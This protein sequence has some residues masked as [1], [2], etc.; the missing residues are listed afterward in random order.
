MDQNGPEPENKPQ[1]DQLVKPRKTTLGRFLAMLRITIFLAVIITAVISILPAESLPTFN[2]NLIFH[3]FSIVIA[4]IV[5]LTLGVIFYL[6]FAPAFH[7]EAAYLR[8]SFDFESM[9]GIVLGSL[10]LVFAGIITLFTTTPSNAMIFGLILMGAYTFYVYKVIKDTWGIQKENAEI[11]KK[12]GELVEVDKEKSDF[13]MITSHQLR[14]PLT[15][16]RW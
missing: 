16:M 3:P 15:E 14:T 1:T 13:I 7:P 5:T 2:L 11:R 9:L 10:G 8:G 4:V 12:Y 6:I